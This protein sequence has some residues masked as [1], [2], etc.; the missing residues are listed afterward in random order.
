[1][2]SGDAAVLA[3]L[4]TEV[5]T[6]LSEAIISVEGVSVSVGAPAATA[7]PPITVDSSDFLSYATDYD[8]VAYPS[9]DYQIAY[10]VNWTARTFRMQLAA[11]AA[12]W[13]GIGFRQGNQHPMANADIIFGRV[14][15]DGSFDISDRS[16]VGP[17]E[18]KEDAE[19]GGTD[20]LFDTSAW[21]E[22]GLTFLRFSFLLKFLQSSFEICILS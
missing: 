7:P 3:A 21:E 1:M 9:Q 19:L 22:G 10:S 18:P 14:Y 16:G 15:G 4:K 12:G 11:K 17:E 2:A 20:D 6:A 13:V 5:Q 8:R